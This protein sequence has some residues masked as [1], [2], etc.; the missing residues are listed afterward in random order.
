M[1][2]VKL[3]HRIKINQSFY[4]EKHDFTV[5]ACKVNCIKQKIKFIIS[6]KL[7]ATFHNLAQFCNPISQ[8]CLQSNCTTLYK[9]NKSLAK[10]CFSFC[11]L[12]ERYGENKSL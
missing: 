8:V 6:Y 10:V 9:L 2:R 7:F 1:L 3:H 4:K 11:F 12:M 5:H